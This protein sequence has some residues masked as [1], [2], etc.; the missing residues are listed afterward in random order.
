MARFIPLGASDR[1]V[2]TLRGRFGNRCSRCV[3]QL[4]QLSQQF[5][6]AFTSP[7]KFLKFRGSG[8]TLFKEFR[9]PIYE[10]AQFDA[11]LWFIVIHIS[12]QSRR[13]WPTPHHLARPTGNTVSRI[14]AWW[15]HC[16]VSDISCRPASKTAYVYSLIRP[17]LTESELDAFLP[18]LK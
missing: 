2:G 14:V 6:D 3:F 7:L 13:Y 11:D 10:V 17:S 1:D 15:W 8:V 5:A 18:E 12:H 4:R 9:L 16:F